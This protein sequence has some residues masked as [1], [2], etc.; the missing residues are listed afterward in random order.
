[1][2]FKTFI[3]E[4]AEKTAVMAFGR[5]NPPTREGHGKVFDKVAEVAK[6]TGGTGHIIASHSENTAKDPLS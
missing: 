4:E 6:R 5:Y 1:M 3:T 2:D